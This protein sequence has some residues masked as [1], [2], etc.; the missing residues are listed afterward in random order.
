MPVMNG[1]EFVT[2]VRANPDYTAVRIVMVTTE[3]EMSQV[4]KALAAGA[5]E[6][7]M[8]PFTTE[9][10]HDKLSMLGFCVA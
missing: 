3:V 1:L 7:V 2:A 4:S 6:Y 9:I 8:K 5:E 10:L